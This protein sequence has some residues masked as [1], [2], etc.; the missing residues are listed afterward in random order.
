MATLI[1]DI[2]CSLNLDIKTMGITKMKDLS[3]FD[4]H[5]LGIKDFYG[6]QDNNIFDISFI[7]RTPLQM[8]AYRYRF[9]KRNLD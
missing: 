3:Y 7:S 2:Y 4:K 6:Y 8:I 1:E 5:I 9:L